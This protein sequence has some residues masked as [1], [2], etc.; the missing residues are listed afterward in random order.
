MHGVEETSLEPR[1][2]INGEATDNPLPLNRGAQFGDGLFET[3]LIRD[4]RL[5]HEK[6]HFERLREGVKRLG[7]NGYSSRQLRLEI[8][9][10][11]AQCIEGVLKLMITRGGAV[12]LDYGL[13]SSATATRTLLLYP[14]PEYPREWA[15]YGIRVHICKTPVGHN[16]RLGG[17]KHMNRLEQALARSEW[18]GMDEFQEGLM[19]DED[20]AV[21]GGTRSNVFA[22]FD[23]GVLATPTVRLCGV[24][25]V[26]RRNVLERAR[27]AGISVRVATMGLAQFMRAQEIFVTNSIIGIWPVRAI[28]H[29]KY[30]V[31]P[32]AQKMRHWLAV[33]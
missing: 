33:D 30:S 8:S 14:K 7:I 6:Y 32:I 17:I 18:A 15:Q 9:R 21:V 29:W 12:A 28:D 26:V 1:C 25:G 11:T 5:C 31:G 16:R 3:V 2:W 19:L 20:G 22:W 4:G 23:H 24:A 10:A 13:D 27:E